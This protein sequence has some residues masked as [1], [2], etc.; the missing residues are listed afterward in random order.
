MDQYPAQGTVP[1]DGVVV[2]N[3]DGGTVY[4]P[5]PSPFKK[6]IPF[7]IILVVLLLVLLVV[8]VFTAG[9]KGKKNEE[10]VPTPTRRPTATPASEA[11]TIPQVIPP[12]ASPSGRL[13]S[14]T[15]VK[16]GRL[17]M[18]K[19][20]DIFHSDVETF[21]LL[22]KNNP[23]AGDRLSWS[24]DGKYLAWRPKSQTATPSA[25]SVYSVGNGAGPKVIKP[26]NGTVS[27]V[28]DYDW[29]KDDAMVIL[30]RNNGLY[31]LSFYSLASSSGLETT[32]LI[33]RKEPI[34]QIVYAGNNQIIYR[35]AEGIGSVDINNGTP[36]KVLI[37]INNKIV[38]MKLSPDKTKIVYAVGNSARS[39]LFIMNV[40]GSTNRKINPLPPKVDM[41][42]TGVN[43][44][45]LEKGFVNNFV[46]FP[47]SNRLLV[48]YHYIAGLPLVGIYNLDEVSFTAVNP[49]IL[50]F[51]DLMVDEERMLGTRIRNTDSGPTW[52]ISLFTLED[53]A[54]LG[55]IRVIPG[56]SAFA[57][58][59]KEN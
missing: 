10:I 30:H 33:S 2:P 23:P 48:G 9:S 31:N 46:F 59:D 55:T 47:K 11:P 1:V 39:D 16:L 43:Q 15:P 12:T 35:S 57:F 18:I 21:T 36:P 22:L 41:G 13:V 25:V 14:I 45:V 42:T 44:S 17:A 29:V 58:Y 5:P 7:V 49:F 27:E 6:L 8:S 37:N 4:P 20:G 52:Q 32:K 53:N 19:D 26:D 28:L 38:N 54:K 40:D 56:V 34:R 3:M 51:T 24:P 50:Y